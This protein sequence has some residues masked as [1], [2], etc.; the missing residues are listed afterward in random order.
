[1]GMYRS[2][3]LIFIL[4]PAAVAGLTAPFSIVT[5]APIIILVNDDGVAALRPLAE[6][7]GAKM[8]VANETVMVT[9][10][11]KSFQCANGKKQALK[12]GV[13]CKLPITPF[14]REGICYVPV[15]S[16]VTALGGTYDIS[17]DSENNPL[18]A[19]IALP[20]AK[21]LR[22][23]CTGY[24]VSHPDDFI[25]DPALFI[26]D[27]DGR[28]QRQL[29]YGDEG[30]ANIA[31]SPDG[32]MIAY[33]EHDAIIL[34]KTNSPYAEKIFG[35]ASSHYSGYSDLSFSPDSRRLLFCDLHRVKGY[36]D[37]SYV[38]YVNTDGSGQR[39]VTKGFNPRWSPDGKFIALADVDLHNILKVYLVDANLEHCH[40]IVEGCWSPCFSADGNNL[41]LYRRYA[42]PHADPKDK[43]PFYY[44]NTSIPLAGDGT[45][46]GPVREP[47]PPERQESEW[48]GCCHPRDNTFV[49]VNSHGIF[50]AD[51]QNRSKKYRVLSADTSLL[52]S[53]PVFSPDGKSIAFRRAE[54]T[55]QSSLWIANVD[56]TG[57]R[58]ITSMRDIY[59]FVFTPDGK[60]LLFAG[61]VE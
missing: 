23:S 6:I 29:S 42:K 25:T 24:R 32:A 12:N 54:K 10:N 8:T 35:A 5:E 28:N 38:Y 27:I 36:G 33:C 37:K 16:L 31:V 14:T 58:R 45:A 20:G 43:D 34:R 49:Y 19:T 59:S 57:L 26:V 44:L 61:S 47:A 22:L 50:V 55:F 15:Q 4:L 11:G 17:M 21:P 2:I 30:I 18:T 48:T 3:L 53:A 41:L 40:A 56:G 1:M 7:L 39:F 52:S 51:I 46:S 60:S 9:R 13:P